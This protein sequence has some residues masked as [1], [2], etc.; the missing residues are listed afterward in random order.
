MN[1]ERK[2]SLVAKLLRMTDGGALRWKLD[3]PSDRTSVDEEVWSA[4]YSSQIENLKFFIIQC[5]YGG[6]R[7]LA[8]GTDFGGAMTRKVWYTRTIL[9]VED[10]D[11]HHIMDTL[12]DIEDLPI[13]TRLYEAVRNSVTGVDERIDNFLQLEATHADR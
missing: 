9:H 7:K 8:P 3:Q 2:V 10:P 12:V 5:S 6:W 1:R 13:L 11:T 4:G